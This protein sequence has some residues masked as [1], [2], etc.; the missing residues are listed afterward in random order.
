MGAERW[1]GQA[2]VRSRMEAN[3]Q[4]YRTLGLELLLLARN[5]RIDGQ[6]NSLREASA[7]ALRTAPLL[8]VPGYRQLTNQM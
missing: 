5:S 1:E 3:Q 8:M 4:Y 7:I 2:I 6:K